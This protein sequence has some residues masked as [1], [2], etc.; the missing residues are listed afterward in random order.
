ML[1][2]NLTRKTQTQNKNSKLIKA[3]NSSDSATANNYRAVRNPYNAV[4]STYNN[5][6]R[7]YKLSGLNKNTI[8]SRTFFSDTKFIKLS[9]DK[10]KCVLNNDELISKT[11]I[12]SGTTGSKA[13]VYLVKEKKSPHKHYIIKKSPTQYPLKRKSASNSVSNS[14]SNSASNSASNSSSN[15]LDNS[16]EKST[17]YLIIMSEAK[18]YNNVMN[19]LVSNYITPYVIMGQ[20][21]INCEKEG[22]NIFLINETGSSV[23][24]KEVLSLEQFLTKYADKLNK[25]IILHILFQIV[26]TLVCFN[27]I[28]FQHND[29]HVGNVLVFIRNKNA[30]DNVNFFKLNNEYYNFKYDKD[31]KTGNFNLYDI[32]IDIRIYD[33]D[34]SF[35]LP[36]NTQYPSLNSAIHPPKDNPSMYTIYFSN[37]DLFTII[38]GIFTELLRIFIKDKKQYNNLLDCLFILQN[39]LNYE[40]INKEI[41]TV[42][43]T[44][45]IVNFEDIFKDFYNR[46]KF[47]E[48]N[49]SSGI[50]NVSNGVNNV[51]SDVNNV[52]SG[53]NSVSSGINISNINKIIKQ[54]LSLFN[55]GKYED[56]TTA[57]NIWIYIFMSKRFFDDYNT[58]FKPEID[59]LLEIIT[60]LKKEYSTIGVN[61]YNILKNNTIDSFDL[62]KLNKVIIKSTKK[63]SARNS[64]RNSARHF[65]G[66]KR[67]PFGS[68]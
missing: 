48:N 58:Y 54:R 26:Y 28:N 64:A 43:D 51:S 36:V 40:K 23:N 53:V 47:S 67:L 49:V 10:K 2:A 34:H 62:R 30:L 24:T 4:P 65:V 56:K 66:L 14:V 38:C 18:M 5:N 39:Y 52:S 13:I 15:L 44:N 29:L 3:R 55:K 31:K 20:G 9:D 45:E 17:E 11:I 61:E 7:K 27:K 50:N 33:F 25:L 6:I 60:L 8:S 12:S 46:Y 68:T 35:K 19:T 42:K 1:S 41:G 32:G 16:I 21:I 59:Y 22:K 37:Q 63:K 57:Q